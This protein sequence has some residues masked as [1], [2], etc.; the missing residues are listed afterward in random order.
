[1]KLFFYIIPLEITKMNKNQIWKAVLNEIE[2]TISKAH[3]V[4]WF[5]NT[6]IKEIKD[7]TVTVAVPNGFSKE[8]LEVK[9]NKQLRECLLKYCPDLKNLEF[10]IIPPESRDQVQSKIKR[11]TQ[12]TQIPQSK[13]NNKF[14]KSI[15]NTINPRYTFDNL[16]EG[17]HNELAKAASEAIASEPGEKYNPLFIYGGVGLGKTHLLHSIGNELIKNNPDCIVHYVTSER[18]TNDFVYAVR[19][20]NLDDFKG[21][22][23]HL[24][25]LLIDDIQFI[26]GKEGTQEQF[27]HTFNNLYSENKQIVLC[28]DRPPKSIP[29]LEDRL[30]SRFEGGMIVDVTKPNI[31]TRMAILLE[32]ANNMSFPIPPETLTY[33]AE[34]ISNNVRELEGYLNK[35]IATCQLRKLQPTIESAKEVLSKDFIKIS[36][37]S[38]SPSYLINQVASYYKVDPKNII[39]KS[40]KSDLVKARQVAIYLLRK[41]SKLSFPAIGKEVGGRDHTTIMHA[42]NKIKDLLKKDPILKQEI[43]DILE[44]EN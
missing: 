21:L 18:F 13:P 10:E 43:D 15:K 22:Y 27:F 44:F 31:E 8:W 24:D 40:R 34:N 32:K 16:V 5:H 35:F 29:A 17:P 25:A 20:K 33:I 37:Q 39:G 30:C 3:F 9:L 19:E 23:R 42:Y 1:V 41:K 11:P 7:N 26:G 2:L 4:T 14:Y 36:N 6:F 38:K 12:T 28:S